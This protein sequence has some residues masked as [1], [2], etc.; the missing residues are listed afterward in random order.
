[1]REKGWLETFGKEKLK[2]LAVVLFFL[3]SGVWYSCSVSSGKLEMGTAI[4]AEEIGKPAEKSTPAEEKMQKIDIN[5]AS[6]EELTLLSG[7]GEQRA[8]N[9]ITYREEQG[10]FQQIEDIMQVSGIGEKTFE[11]I[12]EQITVGE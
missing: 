3:C 2:F 6:A 9:I 8:A 7:I 1:M 5:H 12:K 4:A 11:K 10:A